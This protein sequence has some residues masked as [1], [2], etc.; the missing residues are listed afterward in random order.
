MMTERTVDERIEVARRV[1]EFLRDP[2]VRDALDK[3]DRSCYEQWQTAKT[4]EER[5]RI[6]ARAEALR[7]FSTELAVQVNDGIMAVKEKAVQESVAR[8]QKQSPTRK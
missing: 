8:Q 2:A 1:E 3:A 5:E 6:H 4:V 7:A